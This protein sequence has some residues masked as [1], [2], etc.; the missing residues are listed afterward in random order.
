MPDL[1]VTTIRMPDSMKSNLAAIARSHDMSAADGSETRLSSTSPHAK[2]SRS[3]RS[4]WRGAWS[5][6]AR[7]STAWGKTKVAQA[8]SRCRADYRQ[9]Q[10]ALR[11]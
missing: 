4:S 9:S 5:R 7:S 2:A 3:S 8:Q 11:R 10:S 1:K 6:T